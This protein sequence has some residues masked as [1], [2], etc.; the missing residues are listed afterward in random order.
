[1]PKNLKQGR[2][3]F[4]TLAGKGELDPAV[5]AT[6]V[7]ANNKKGGKVKVTLLMP[8]DTYERVRA[9]AIKEGGSIK[10]LSDAGVTLIEQ[11]L[12]DYD[13]GLLKIKAEPVVLARKSLA[14]G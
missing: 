11:G 3:P 13:L 14:R 9:I 7:R 10:A 12:A 6:L 4:A 5:R 2:D 1:M 8:E